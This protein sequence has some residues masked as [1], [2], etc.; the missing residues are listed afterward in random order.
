VTIQKGQS[1]TWVDDTSGPMWVASA[2]HPTHT[3]YDGTTEATHCSG[4]Y[5]GPTPFDQCQGGSTYTFV[6]SK[7]GSFDFHN[8]LAAQFEGTVVVQ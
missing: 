4:S 1:V 2:S 8:H 5:T 6:F 3:A 7:T